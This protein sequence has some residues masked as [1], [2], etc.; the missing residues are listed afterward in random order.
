L[1]KGVLSNPNSLEWET[2]IEAEVGDK[3]WMNWDA[4]LIAAKNKRLKF[5]IIN[6]EKYIIINYKDLYVGKRGDEEDVVC[7]N[8]YC[9]IEALKNIELPGY[10][11]DRSRGIINTQMHDNKLNPKYG[12]LAYAGTVNSKY[13]YPGEDIIDSDGILP[14]DLVMLSNNSDVMLEYP[15]HTKFDGKK[16][17]YRVH[18]HQ[19]LAKI[20]SVEN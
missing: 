12:R 4:I 20:D 9:L 8:G 16:I 17:F 15:I 5:F 7:Y 11:R 10:F 13:Y 6:D 19:I 18:R 14:G 3:V 2:D 1:I